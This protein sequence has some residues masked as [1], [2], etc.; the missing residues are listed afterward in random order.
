M[1]FSRAEAVLMASRGKAT[2]INFL[3][4]L[5]QVRFLYSIVLLCCLAGLSTST[6]LLLHLPLLLRKTSQTMLFYVP[7]SYKYAGENTNGFSASSSLSER[8]RHCPS[9]MVYW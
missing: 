9:V 1:D 6:P 2:S 3:R 4:S 7:T 8:N 5:I